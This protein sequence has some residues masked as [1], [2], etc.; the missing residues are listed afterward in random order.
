MFGLLQ[1][2]KMKI[3]AEKPKFHPTVLLT[4][5]GDGVH[6]LFSLYY[7]RKVTVKGDDRQK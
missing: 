3:I 5:I 1:G 7:E 4:D 6:P 2:K